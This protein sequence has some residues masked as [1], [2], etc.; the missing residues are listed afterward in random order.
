M[1]QLKTAFCAVGHF[2]ARTGSA[3]QE[4]L[5]GLCTC[6]CDREAPDRGV[7]APGT[8]RAE[9]PQSHG[10]WYHH[11]ALRE[12]NPKLLK[13]RKLVSWEESCT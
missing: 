11:V 12:T 3:G 2:Q 9:H 1:T 6:G 13:A 10:L 5:C 7:T 8:G 4:L